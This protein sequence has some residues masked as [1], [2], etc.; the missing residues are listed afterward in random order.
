VDV[1]GAVDM[2]DQEKGGIDG[3]ERKI[4]RAKVMAK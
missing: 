4:Q 1:E 3:D 2:M